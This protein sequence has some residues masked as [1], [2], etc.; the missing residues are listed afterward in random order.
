MK[1]EN[2]KVLTK[3]EKAERRKE[4]KYKLCYNKVLTIVCSI[5]FAISAVMCGLGY[6]FVEYDYM[7]ILGMVGTCASILL[8]FLIFR[9]PSLSLMVMGA[10]LTDIGLIFNNSEPLYVGI[11]AFLSS[12]ILIAI[13]SIIRDKKRGNYAITLDHQFVKSMIFD[14]DGS[15]SKNLTYG[16]L[17]ET[18]FKAKFYFV[19]A[20]LSILAC[21]VGLLLPFGK[22][23]YLYLKG[24]GFLTCDV[25]EIESRKHN[26]DK[27]YK[28]LVSQQ[29][30]YIENKSFSCKSS[31]FNLA[32][33][34]S[35]L[36]FGY[37]IISI[38][39]AALIKKP[40]FTEEDETTAGRVVFSTK[41]VEGLDADVVEALAVY[42]KTQSAESRQYL[43]DSLQELNDSYNEW[44]E[45]EGRRLQAYEEEKWRSA[46]KYATDASVETDGQGYYVSGTY[47]GVEGKKKLE[48]YDT[49][50]GVGYYT[51][52]S[53]KKVEVRNTNFKK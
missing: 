6:K 52:E 16:S 29:E 50:T 15:L 1:K 4:N 30:A 36:G 5:L 12:L 53:G 10:A 2:K 27:P 35:L 19:A 26:A 40:T 46:R 45:R 33:I 17:T 28:N 11:I 49:Q 34:S 9:K 43:V 37:I 21:G 14:D 23:A 31:F 42:S 7:Y 24:L 38:A 44:S 22:K 41:T 18:H 48:G 13:S 47:D 32:N 8:P 39:F 51:D 3:E 25:K 20:I